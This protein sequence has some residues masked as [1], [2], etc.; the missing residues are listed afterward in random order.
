MDIEQ[1][2]GYAEQAYQLIIEYGLQL[3]GAIAA[4]IIGLIVIKQITNGFKKLLEKRDVDVS[5][6]PFLSGLINALLKAL[7]IVSILGMVGIEMTSFIAILGAASLAIG[8]ALSGT[9][10][11]FAGG[12]LILIFKP[13]KVGD[14]VEMQGYS[15]SVNAINI[16][17]TVLKT[18]DNKT[19]LIPNGPI[20]VGSLTNYST[21]PR[22][23]VDW[24]V[25]IGYGDDIDKARKIMLD[26]IHADSRA[27]KDPEPFIKVSALADSSVNF[28]VR[29][30]VE[31]SDYWPLYFDFNEA[32]YKKFNEE[33]I[34]IPFPQMD[35][36][37][38]QQK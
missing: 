19:I 15:G 16:I 2:N 26:I 18:P 23:R 32:I 29:V 36:H 8:M 11:N 25:G 5:L 38:H 34:N 31:A 14:W 22:R 21:E 37:V 17:N 35:V 12:V 4:L 27:L 33:G 6:R 7:L 28:T 3:V 24:T 30:W 20:S 9:L 1:L 10:Q 13:Y